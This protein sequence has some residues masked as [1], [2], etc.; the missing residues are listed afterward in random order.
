MI[1]KEVVEH[2]DSWLLFETC[3]LRNEAF[4]RA[5]PMPDW[6]QKQHEAFMA[7]PVKSFSVRKLK[8]VR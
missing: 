5:N 3:R 6:M 1:K 8:G 4:T 7:R 2:G